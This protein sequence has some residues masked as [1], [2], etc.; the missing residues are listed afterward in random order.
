MVNKISDRVKML[1]PGLELD[2]TTSWKKR[3]GLTGRRFISGDQK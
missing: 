3:D 1:C 2:P